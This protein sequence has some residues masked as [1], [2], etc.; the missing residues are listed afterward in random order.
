MI[1]SLPQGLPAGAAL[2]AGILVCID[3]GTIVVATDGTKTLFV[4]RR[5]CASGEIPEL[6]QVGEIVEITTDGNVTADTLITATT[7]GAGVSATPTTAAGP[8]NTA[9]RVFAA[10]IGT[11]ARMLYLPQYH[12]AAGA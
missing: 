11:K 10:D 5:A 7:A 9:G 3:S 4:T 2:A 8:R 6:A 12:P 1:A